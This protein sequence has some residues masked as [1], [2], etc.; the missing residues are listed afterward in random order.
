MRAGL[1]YTRPTMPRTFAI[2]LACGLAVVA[3]TAPLH[4]SGAAEIPLLDAGGVRGSAAAG[5]AV[6]DR[7]L[8]LDLDFSFEVGIATGVEIA[9]P[10]ALGV[11]ILDGGPGSAL[12]LGVG[13]VDLA[14]VPGTHVIYAPA[15]VLAGQA[16][17]GAEAT[18]RGAFDVSGAE[19]DLAEGD[20]GVWVRGSLGLVVDVGPWLSAGLGFSYQREV[21]SALPPEGVHEAGW[22]SGSR[23]SI[24]AVRSQPFADLPTLSVHLDAH[25][26]FVLL[27]RVDIDTIVET[28]DSRYLLGLSVA[29]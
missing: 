15:A 16:R 6:L 19:E 9:W 12:Y 1:C 17:M 5:L 8:S 13:I 23:V 11:R 24:G 2:A 27:V 3:L 25:V 22:V 29:R 18:F 26:D 21:V 14:I 7:D 28:T 4:A 20:Q 10:L